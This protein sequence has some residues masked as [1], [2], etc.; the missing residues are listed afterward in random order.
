MGSV[1]RSSLHVARA[2]IHTRGASRVAQTFLGVTAHRMS[3]SI[4]N[5]NA[6]TLPDR[7]AAGGW[8]DYLSLMK[9]RV[10]SLVVFT[11][12]AGLVGAPVQP[13]PIIALVIILAIAVGAGASGALNMAYD[14]DIDA[15]MRRTRTRPIPAGRI[16]RAEAATLGV[17]MSV[18]SV[19]V[20]GLAANAFAAGLL[21]F[22]IVFY[23]VVYTIW[24]KR[25]TVQNIVIGGLA[26]A[27][28]PAVAWAGATGDLSLTPL[29]LVAIIFMW[30]P[31]HFWALSLYKAGEYKAAGVPMLPVVRGPRETRRQI[32][33]YT[34]ILAPLGLTPAFIGAGGVVYLAVAMGG[35]AL[36]LA[37][38][39]KVLRSRAGEAVY[40]GADAATLYAVKAGDR[41]AR[42]LFA[43]SI[44]YLFA[45][46][47]VFLAE[48]LAGAPALNWSVPL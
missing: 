7:T 11:A 6:N 40:G 3:N 23:A 12:C 21:A 1:T 15:K 39:W 28:P 45:L 30:T 33:L 38:A 37:L 27:L 10:M 34:L 32:F 17:V 16:S 22:T 24:L 5:S 47:G 25:S 48:H 13:H 2:D 14:A 20:L 31:P 26:G 43:A 9:P 4:A 35:G 44:L 46:F 29:V 41:A 19:M 36:M 8:R 18:L 42:N